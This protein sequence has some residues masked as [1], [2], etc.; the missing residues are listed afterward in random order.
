MWFNLDDSVN[1]LSLLGAVIIVA[2][3]IGVFLNYI[4]K[5][6][7]SRA[8]GE[9]KDGEWDGIKEFKNDLPVG[10]AVAYFVLIIW[11]IWY[12]FFGY[13]LNAFS[14]IG[15]WNEEVKEYQTK[16]EDKWKDADSETLV[17][18]G[19]SIFL[20]QCA[21]C[22]G[23]TAEGMNGKAQDLVTWAKEN[24]IVHVVANGSQGLGFP[25]GMPPGMATPEDAKKAAAYIMATFTPFK[26]TKYPDLVSEGKTVYDSVCSACHGMDGKGITGVAPAF[27]DLVA[28]VLQ[29][30]KKGQIGKMPSFAG[31]FGA[32]QEKALDYYIYSLSD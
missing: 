20:V 1:A 17:N 3:T 11:G 6:K 22:H 30:G 25:G 29:H 10:W 9:L 23:E 14:Q 12:W 21:P 7:D 31:R 2:L 8:E 28:A 32:V 19:Q 18:M 27:T 26:K 5:M 16:F 4:K 13:P 24:W 15:Q